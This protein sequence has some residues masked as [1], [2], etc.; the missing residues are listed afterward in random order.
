MKRTLKI[1]GA[2]LFIG[3]TSMVVTGCAYPTTETVQGGESS[4]IYFESF[5][6]EATV[7]V[8]GQT[9]GTVGD[10][11]GGANTLAVPPGTHEVVISQNGTVIHNKKVFVGR[12]SALKITR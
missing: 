9:A 2:A 10:Y 1:L 11:D 3:S 5:P 4:A 7:I 12:N 6:A 8:D